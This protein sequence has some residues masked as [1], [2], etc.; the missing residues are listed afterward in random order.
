MASLLLLLSLSLSDHNRINCRGGGASW[1]LGGSQDRE[2]IEV[3]ERKDRRI[4]KKGGTAL[5]TRPLI[6]G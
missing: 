6:A 4:R 3:T 5:V 1:E 2:A